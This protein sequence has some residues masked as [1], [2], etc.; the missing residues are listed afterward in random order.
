FTQR[1]RAARWICLGLV[2]ALSGCGGGSSSDNNGSST[3]LTVSGTAATGAALSGT[4]TAVGANSAQATTPIGTGGA[5]TLNVDG[6]TFP[7]LIKADDGVGTV[8]YSWAD[9]SGDIANIT[10]LT[11]LA[12]VLTDL[13]DNLTEVFANWATASSQLTAATLQSAQAKVNANLQSQFTAEGV[14]ASSYDFLTTAFSA[15]G[16]G[17]DGVL[18][19]LVFNFDY[20]GGTLA[21]VVTVNLA[22]TA[23][24]VAINIEVDTSAITI[25]GGTGGS[26]TCSSGWCLAVSGTVV[27]GGVTA[28]VPVTTVPG[29]TS[30]VVPTLS[31]GGNIEQSIQSAYGATGTITDLN[32]TIVS[33]SA[34]ETVAHLTFNVAITSPVAMTAAYDLTYTYTKA[35]GGGTS[36]GD[37]GGTT[38]G[39]CSGTLLTYDDN[40]QNS[41]ALYTDGQKVCFTASSTTLSFL[42]KTLTNPTVNIIVVAPYTAYTF[43]AI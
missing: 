14:E 36:G 34:T 4:V 42:D 2:V 13:S 19:G 39:S 40:A 38:G 20:L 9:A 31:D 7:L 43:T 12:L 22:G 26:S 27:T 32:Y 5:Y 11:T 18:D 30:D 16:S 24:A 25:G 41:L 15:D 1:H 10:P 8:L 33:S 37:T 23:T 29:L 21:G 35:S 17:I 28:N 3:S 6:L